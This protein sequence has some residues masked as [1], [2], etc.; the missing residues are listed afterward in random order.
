MIKDDTYYT[1]EDA[2]KNG[3]VT[4]IIGND[5]NFN[6]IFANRAK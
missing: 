3:I 6:H 2:M 1:A 4:E 5:G